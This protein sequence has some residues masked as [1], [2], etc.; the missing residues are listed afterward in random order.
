M[1]TLALTGECNLQCRYCYQNAKSGASMSWPVIRSAADRLLESAS[2][3]LELVFAGGEP[4]LALETIRRAVGYIERRRSRDRAVQYNLAT[5]GTLLSRQAIAFLRGHA[6][7]IQLSFDGVRP[8]QAVRGTRS[9]ALIDGA[10]DRL[11]ADAPE[12]FWRRLTVGVTLDADAVLYLA[13]SFRYFLDKHV[14]AIVV[15]PAGGQAARWTPGVIDTLERQLEAVYEISYRHCAD[16]GTVPLT[17]FR[18]TPDD[19]PANTDVVCGGA[20]SGSVTVDVDGET[21]ACPFLAES[22]QRFANQRLAAI[23]RPLRTG[24]IGAP[25]FW[26]RLGDLP[27]RARGTG[28][29]RI[30]PERH[31]LHGQCLECPHHLACMACPISVLFEP[32]HD[33]AHR[34]PDYICAFNWA[35]MSLRQKFPVQPDAAALLEGRAPRPRLARELLERAGAGR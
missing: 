14:P 35:L 27:L 32:D 8:A 6:F 2:D 33:D 34:I 26:R 21:Y 16:T 7:A 23:V 13:E 30:G 31:A 10:L 12:I 18:K 4:L 28:M 9:F 29:F 17:A 20:A 25:T 24:H 19:P 1:M 22:S 15:L 11:R 5:N 3:R